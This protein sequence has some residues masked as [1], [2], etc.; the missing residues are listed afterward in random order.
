MQLFVQSD[1]SG[2]SLGAALTSRYGVTRLLLIGAGIVG[3]RAFLVPRGSRTFFAVAS[4][5]AIVAEAL[6][7][8][9]ATGPLPLIGVIADVTH[10]LGAALWI[11]VLLVT[12]TAAECVDVR[13][14]SNVATICVLAIVVSA[15]PQALRGIPSLATL[16]TTEYGRLVCAK[17]ALLLLAL[18][19]ALISRRRVAGGAA[20]VGRSV[21]FEV[22]VLT[23]VLAVTAVLVDAP[24]PRSMAAAANVTAQTSFDAGSLHVTVHTTGAGGLQRSFRITTTRA[25]A[26]A[27]AD[28]VDATISESRT[29]TGPLAVVAHPEKTGTYSG[30]TTLPFPGRWRLFVSVRSGAFDEGHAALRL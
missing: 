4:L 21:R 25:G 11:G 5:V 23:G 14:T 17:A 10:L 22:A 6:S 9:A 18:A 3:F 28:G 26:P 2:L 15:I 27:N 29:G 16:A 1:F 30:T 24:P 8:H 13:R 7:G 12:L 20:A 19:F